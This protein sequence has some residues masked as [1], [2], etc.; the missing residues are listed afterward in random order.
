MSFLVTV[1]VAPMAVVSIVALTQYIQAKQRRA[2]RR[3]RDA[4]RK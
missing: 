1:I 3:R 4:E 2:E